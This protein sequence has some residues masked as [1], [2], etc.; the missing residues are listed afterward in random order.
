MLVLLLSVLATAPVELRL[1]RTHATPL[2]ASH[3]YRALVNGVEIDRARHVVTVDPRGAVVFTHS[4]V[5]RF[6][7]AVPSS[8]SDA[9]LWERAARAV[10][11]ALRDS[12]GVPYGGLQR[13][14]FLVGGAL[15][16]GAWVFVPTPR[17]TDNWHVAVD[18]V[19]GQVR[20][21]ENR[22]FT[23]ATTAAVYLPSPGGLDGGVGVTPTVAVE[24]LRRDGGAML[25]PDSGVLAG[26]HFEAFNCCV[27]EG[28]APNGSPRVVANHI[29]VEADGGFWGIDGGD[30]EWDSGRAVLRSVVCDRRH[31]ATNDVGQHPSGDFVYAPVDGPATL[32]QSSPEY[33]D[34]FAEVQAFFHA[35]RMQEWLESL[36]GPAPFQFRDARRSAPVPL[37]VQTNFLQADPTSDLSGACLL[38]GYCSWTRFAPIGN[39]MFVPR[40]QYAVTKLPELFPDRDGVYFFQGPRLDFAYDA[41][42]VRH[43]LGHGVVQA[44]A[45]LRF[46]TP[47]V[48]STWANDE[49]GAL[50]EGLA[51]YLAAAQVNDPEVGRYLGPNRD[52]SVDG[53]LR[54]TANATRCPDDLWG[55]RHEDGLLISGA[56]WE[57]RGGFDAQRF[58]TAVY[59][60]LGALAPSADFD[61]TAEAVA[62]MVGV[63]FPERADA[64]ASVRAVFA[65]RGVTQCVHLREADGG[66]IEVAAYGLASPPLGGP[67]GEA[68]PGPYQFRFVPGAAGGTFEI[69]ARHQS[70]GLRARLRAGVPVEFAPGPTGLTATFDAEARIDDGVSYLPVPCGPPQPLYLAVT[71]SASW[72][73]L[74]QPFSITWKPDDRCAQ[75]VAPVTLPPLGQTLGRA[76]CGCDSAAALWP[77]LG[78]LALRR[79][80]RESGRR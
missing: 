20:A 49:G 56:L 41:T 71:N 60:A 15:H 79:R 39:A 7:R 65:A 2:G 51:D 69:S 8:L 63:A 32:A 1:E 4:D 52:R 38:V 31:L 62:T 46:A 25:D 55:T 24:L 54:S 50:N 35:N 43:E 5:P 10:P 34:A 33:S 76:H 14:W 59:A 21:R 72:P 53:P 9:E 68:L 28:C 40:E 45:N 77:L 64:V 47:R 26:P 16:G 48:A 37:M 58:D 6:E 80:Q 11:F 78:A 23:A 36:S 12:N 13:T 3:R 18:G 19:T 61:T 70:Y 29:Y 44:T 27:N 42:V 75:T 67:S 66:S 74:F 30:F 57:A 73:V 22:V 17:E